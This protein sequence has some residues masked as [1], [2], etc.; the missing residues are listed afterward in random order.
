MPSHS[1]YPDEFD[2]LTQC[3][4]QSLLLLNN[5]L[6][7]PLC[8]LQLFLHLVQ[9]LVQLHS[10]VRVQNLQRETVRRKSQ[11]K[12]LRTCTADEQEVKQGQ[13]DYLC[14]KLLRGMSMYTCA[15]HNTSICPEFYHGG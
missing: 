3:P 8:Y 4:L 12:V 9:C 1:P 7:L 11:M 14:Y 15:Q 5:T 13:E 6:H 10:Q 2:F